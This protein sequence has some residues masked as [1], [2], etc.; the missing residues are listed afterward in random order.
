MCVIHRK[1]G[2]EIRVSRNLSLEHIAENI[3]HDSY[4]ST[5]QAED[6]TNNDVNE[7]KKV[8]V[9]WFSCYYLT[10]RLKKK[11]QNCL[12]VFAFLNKH[13]PVKML[14]TAKCPTYIILLMGTTRK[15]QSIK[16]HM[17]LPAVEYCPL[18]GQCLFSNTVYRAEVEG[19]FPIAYITSTECVFRKKD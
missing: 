14:V 12:E 3:K 19:L 16:L 4:Q 17:N 15:C 2:I 8:Y 13:I 7:K 6:Y 18:N 5:L 10:N 9:N 1:T 11:K